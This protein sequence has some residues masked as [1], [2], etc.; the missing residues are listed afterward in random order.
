MDTPLR[1]SRPRLQLSLP[2]WTP[3]WQNSRIG[4]RIRGRDGL[5]PAVDSTS[6]QVWALAAG[7]AGQAPQ[8]GFSRSGCAW[9]TRLLLPRHTRCLQRNLFSLPKKHTRALHAQ[10]PKLHH[11]PSVSRTR[12]SVPVDSCGSSG[13]PPARFWKIERA[14]A[15]LRGRVGGITGLKVI[16]SP[17]VRL[18][19]W[20]AVAAP[21][22]RHGLGPC[23]LQILF[24]PRGY[25]AVPKS[26]RTEL[27][28][29]AP[30]TAL[31]TSPCSHGPF[32]IP[33]CL[34]CGCCLCS[35][36]AELPR[37]RTFIPLP[38]PLLPWASSGATP[39]RDWSA[40]AQPAQRP[41]YLPKLPT[42][43]CS[44]P[45]SRICSSALHPV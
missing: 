28:R 35:A 29:Q 33:G 19:S 24:P 25:R 38:R 13:H 45:L 1:C 37:N 32:F 14:P 16:G 43:S 44:L 6:T 41:V 30:P 5:S 27:T 26:C 22:G 10:T 12:R 40:P 11:H 42:S 39:H 3:W 21:S 2:P 36:A 20:T 34:C 18:L 9:A 17:S 23:C 31:P 7:L 8:P 4:G 15:Q